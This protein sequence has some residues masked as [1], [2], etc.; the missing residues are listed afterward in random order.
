MAMTYQNFASLGVNLN[1]QKYGPLDISNVF[2]SEAD[3]RYYL[4]KGAVVEG[5]S[6]YWYKSASEKVVPYPYEGQVLAT[7]IDGVVSVFALALDL[8][9]DF[10]TQEIGG[11]VT[12]DEQ[13]ISVDEDGIVS[14]FGFEAADSATLPQKTPVYKKD[15]LGAETEVIDHYEVRW[16]PISAIVEGDGNTTSVVTAVDGS[17]ITVTPSYNEET[18]TY[19]YTLDVTIPAVPEYTVTKAETEGGFNYSITKDGVQVGETIFVPNAYDDSDIDSRISKIEGDYTDSTKL[20]AAI[21]P[22]SDAVALKANAADVY[23]KTEV[24]AKVAALE[25]TTHFIGVKETL[26]ESA[27]NGDICI[28]GNKE[29]VYDANSEAEVKW[30]EIGDTAAEVERISTL[31]SSMTDAQGDIT[32]LDNRITTLEETD[33]DAYVAADA[34]LKSQLEAQIA[35]K[36]DKI[37]DNV[38]DAYGSAQAVQD[39]L[40]SLSSTVTTLDSKTVKGGTVSHT[41]DGVTEGATFNEGSLDIVIDAYKKSETYTRS[42]VDTAITNKISDFTGGESA[43][44]VLSAL[45]DYKKATDAEIYGSDKVASWTDEDGKYIPSY[46]AD[47]RIDTVESRVSTI[48]GTIGGEESGLVA[49]V[50]TL[51]TS[52]KDNTDNISAH[53]TRIGNLET[54]TATD[55]TNLTALQGEVSTLKNTHSAHETA[56]ATKIGEI[57]GN[58]STIDSGYKAAD[59][60]LQ[61]NIDKKA[62]TTYVDAQVKAVDDKIGTVT[63]GKTVVEMI[64][65]AKTDSTY[66]DTAIRALITANTEAINTEKTRAEAKEQE[67]AEQIALLTNGVDPDKIDG[68]NDLID[69][70]DEHGSEVTGILNRLDTHSALLMGIGGEGQPANVLAAIEAASVK[71]ATTEVIGGIKSAD[72]AND[73]VV[74]VDENGIGRVARINVNSL[75][76][77]AGEYLILNGGDAEVSNTTV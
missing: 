49:D 18:D 61:S 63:E 12:A 59:A 6:E 72:P 56:V 71:I 36:Q 27:N 47:S 64:E 55:R 32:A 60:T 45:N 46:T 42:E 50:N 20:A 5:V 74:S 62:D 37:G 33:F 44:D 48:E 39:N 10:V 9:G 7:V 76:Q 21:K 41:S 58:I 2:T 16:V 25:G 38:Y 31:E 8:N 34:T 1:R 15:E 54:S 3:L 13:S 23:N 75:V 57:E 35:E 22:V 68:V 69:Y 67:L 40:T 65:D 53:T 30:V 77:T 28:V 43:A 26:P 19:T 17:A 51:K 66:D 29:Y 73:N 4:T 14:L 52:V 24:D 11:K 70:V